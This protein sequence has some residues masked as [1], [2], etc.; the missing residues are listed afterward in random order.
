[1]GRRI[2]PREWRGYGPFARGPEVRAVECGSKATAFRAAAHLL[3]GKGGLRLE[4]CK[5]GKPG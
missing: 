2:T 1:V 5:L 4:N 3:L